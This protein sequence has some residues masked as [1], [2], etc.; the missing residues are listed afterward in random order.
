MK[1]SKLKNFRPILWHTFRKNLGL[2][3]AYWVVLAVFPLRSIISV[4]SI[5]QRY[6][7]PQEINQLKYISAYSIDSFLITAIALVFTTIVGLRAFSYLHNKRKT[8]YYGSLPISRRTHLF[9]VYTSLAL[10]TIIPLFL[11]T[12]ISVLSAGFTNTVA[13]LSEL[14]GIQVLAVLGNISF[15]T[16]LSV[17]SGTLVDM[18]VSYSL[19]NIGIPIIILLLNVLASMLPGSGELSFFEYNFF[20]TTPYNPIGMEVNLPLVTIFSPLLAPFAVNKMPF[21]ENIVSRPLPT[22][23]HTT[24]HIIWWVILTVGMTVL[25]LHLI[26][27]RRAE[28]AQS[29]FAFVQARETVKTV[30]GIAGGMLGGFIV[31][32]I[33]LDTLEGS[34]FALWYMIGFLMFSFVIHI[35]LQ[36]VYNKNIKGIKKFLLNWGISAIFGIGAFVLIMTGMFGYV[37][38]VPQAS[39]VESVSFVGV[40]DD[41]INQLSIDEYVEDDYENDGYHTI[42]M[43]EKEQIK[44]AIKL[45]ENMIKFAQEQS[46]FI[47]QQNYD[48]GNSYDGYEDL[49]D[50]SI[51][52]KLK[53]GSTL[54]RYYTANYGY[55]YA[56]DKNFKDII[57]EKNISNLK[58][59][60]YEK[61]KVEIFN[62]DG[63]CY[64]FYGKDYAE[65]FELDK[66]DEKFVDKTGTHL[67]S[68]IEAVKKDYIAKGEAKYD[69]SNPKEYISII[70]STEDSVT[71]F[72]IDKS[73]K[74]TLNCLLSM[75]DLNNF[76]RESDEEN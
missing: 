27:K 4:M 72:N 54:T 8:D 75:K 6:A 58:S 23:P 64:N 28:A 47:Y 34:A 53:D 16:L 67:K 12:V 39:E 69:D 45:H 30:S 20:T 55:D 17:F 19:V 71:D 62:D 60:E 13:E 57:V 14:F 51:I 49:S 5:N 56:E 43:T 18:I 61:V 22:A 37:T 29:G 38:R 68:W 26:G 74:N 48:S 36:M 73:Y 44:S 70:I 9:S 63:T 24:F 21:I 11:S 3:I 41:S 15:I 40:S 46:I 2:C 42:V 66:Q 1:S 50:L 7:T 35:V 59:F 25:A 31:S 32:A 33:V 76:R 65:Y 52:Y 10:M